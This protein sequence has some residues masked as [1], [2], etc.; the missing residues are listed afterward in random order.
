MRKKILVAFA[1]AVATAAFAPAMASASTA[2][3]ALHG[4]DTQAYLLDAG[5]SPITADE[6][7]TLS[8]S[9][10][11]V[12]AA[13]V[14]CNSHFTVTIHANGES[15]VSAPSSFTGCTTNIP[16]CNVS[17]VPNLDFGD[18]LVYDIGGVFRDRI[19]VSLTNT[20]SGTCPYGPITYTG[21][22]SP[23]VDIDTSTDT[24]TATFDGTNAGTLSSAL[25][26]AYATNS[27]SGSANGN[28]GFGT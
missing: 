11:L 22:L 16:G 8:G 9:L 15:T 2:V 24:I 20:Y 18:R 19:N 17:A 26:S 7:F 1:A 4:T 10:T 27:V 14:T 3:P 23:I 28:T 21:E 25:G 6:T 5:G 12:G 13:Q